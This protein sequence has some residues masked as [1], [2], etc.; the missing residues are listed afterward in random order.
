MAMF[1]ETKSAPRDLKKQKN[2]KTEAP[3]KVFPARKREM[4]PVYK[5]Q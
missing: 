4:I 1:K 5:E 3:N 2:K